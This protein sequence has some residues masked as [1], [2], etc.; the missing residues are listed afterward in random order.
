MSAQCSFYF[1]IKLIYIYLFFFLLK[2][3]HK[4]NFIFDINYKTIKVCICTVGKL[5][6]NYIKE[7]VEHYQKYNVDKIFLYDNNEI[8]DE[9]FFEVL[10]DYIKNK[11]V[12][13]INYRGKRKEQYKMYQECYENNYK[14]YDWLIYY[15]I[16]EFI[17]LKNYTNIKFFLGQKQ[18]AHC[19][20]IYLNWVLHTDNELLFYDNRTLKERFPKIKN[21]KK[22]CLGK[23]II[24]GNISRIK[25]NSCH[26]LDRKIERCDGF[27]K[28]FKPDRIYCKNPDFDNFYIDHYKYKSTEEYINKLN[29]GDCLY[30][31]NNANKKRKIMSYFKFNKINNKKINFIKNMTNIDISELLTIN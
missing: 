25:I 18:F 7:F 11:Y 9:D 2:K 6:N 30:G 3:S 24:R 29:R 10:S 14:N 20:S 15:D 22:F 5:E 26:L 12:E 19:Q 16:D 21:K 13:I 27:G 28:S 8:N 31:Y 4:K 1:F 23:T 17:H